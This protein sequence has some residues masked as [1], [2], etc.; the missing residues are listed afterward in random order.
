MITDA[1]ERAQPVGRDHRILAVIPARGGS[2]SIPRKN[3]VDLGG[4][5]LLAWS[6]A[7][8]AAVPSIDRIIVSTDDPVI[9]AVAS[10]YDAEVMQRPAALATDTALVIDAVR[11]L[12]ARLRNEGWFPDICVLL[13]PTCPL[14]SPTDIRACLSLLD[15]DDID[16]VAT[17]KPAEL[18]P[19]RAWKIEEGK[20]STVVP[21]VNPWLPRQQLPPAYQL[22]G[23]VYAFRADRLDDDRDSI[24]FGRTAAVVMPAERS[25]DIDTWL[26]LHLAEAMITRSAKP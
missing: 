17:F 24:L 4:K 21:G 1:A 14:R 10:R 25:V 26:D 5:P 8:A 9:S 2:Q 15:D 18:H 7:A 19:H 6:I 11:D 23:A 12:L 22:N 20:P 16:S 3:V 13:E